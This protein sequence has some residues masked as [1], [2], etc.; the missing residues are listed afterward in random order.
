LQ[1]ARA[2]RRERDHWRQALDR[3][4]ERFDVRCGPI[5]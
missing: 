3:V 5:V 1:F 4:Q 2:Y